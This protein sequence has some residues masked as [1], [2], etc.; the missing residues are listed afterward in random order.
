MGWWLLALSA[1]A[2]RSPVIDMHLHAEFWGAGDA[3]LVGLPSPPT[4]DALRD[5][6]LEALRREHVVRAVTSGADLEAWEAADPARIVS[7]VGWAPDRPV[8]E[9]RAA[10]VAH[11]YEAIAEFAPQYA[12]L[13]PN[14]PSLEPWW[15]LA[16]ALDVPVGIHMGLGPPGGWL[17][18]TPRYR[19]ALSDPLLLEEVLVRHPKLR[20]YVMHAGWPMLDG[21]LALMHSYPQVYVDIGVIDWAL[22]RA[23]FYSYLRR[24][25]EAGYGR[26]IL[27]G[28][29]Q[30]S[31]PDAI[32]RSIRAVRRAPFLSP[33]QKRD[34]LYRNAAR[35][36]RWEDL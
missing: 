9:V 27:Y 20:I 26:R 15:A 7:G 28:S 29:D 22:P 6:T 18:A 1:C 17:E 24:L 30:M 32:P 12:G 34:I 2:H 5:A 16:E 10:L 31:W 4:A 3:P 25:V 23:E 35:F 21:M 8:E 36:M 13:A 19:A 11:R 14:D 33:A